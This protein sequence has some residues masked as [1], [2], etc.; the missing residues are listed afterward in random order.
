MALIGESLGYSGTSADG[1]NF[2]SVL[3]RLSGDA[4]YVTSAIGD[5]STILKDYPGLTLQ[6]LDALRDSAILSG[7]DVDSIDPYRNGVAS[8][9]ANSPTLGGD[10]CCCCCCCGVTGAVRRG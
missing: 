3:K 1:G 6:E 7:V 9:T 2:R 8:R 10:G 4:A 5:P